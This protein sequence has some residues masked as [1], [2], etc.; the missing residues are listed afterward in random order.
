MEARAVHSLIWT[1]IPKLLIQK[2]EDY[3]RFFLQQATCK[4]SILMRLITTAWHCSLLH[5]YEVAVP[6]VCMGGSTV[7]CFHLFTKILIFV[8]DLPPLNYSRKKEM[9]RSCTLGYYRSSTSTHYSYTLPS[10]G[11]I[12]T[13]RAVAI[14][15]FHDKLSVRTNYADYK[16]GKSHA[17]SCIV[18]ASSALKVSPCKEEIN[19][20]CAPKIQQQKIC[21]LGHYGHKDVTVIWWAHV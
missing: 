2:K 11:S 14:T 5:S 10:L 15:H 4:R 3:W 18:S 1:L 20:W 9:A 7:I 8:H 17:W 16:V 12:Y 13:K 6:L 19:F 21:G